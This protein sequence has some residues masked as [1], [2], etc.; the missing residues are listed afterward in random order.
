MINAGIL[1]RHLCSRICLD[2]EQTAL[3]LL[4]SSRRGGIIRLEF[5]V[6]P[7][8]FTYVFGQVFDPRVDF[9]SLLSMESWVPVF[10]QTPFWMKRVSSAAF[11]SVLEMFIG[12]LLPS[13]CQETVGE[14]GRSIILDGE[15]RGVN[16]SFSCN[17]RSKRFRRGKFSH[18]SCARCQY[19]ENPNG[20]FAFLIIIVSAEVLCGCELIVSGHCPAVHSALPMPVTPVWKLTISIRWAA[21]ELG[22]KDQW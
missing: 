2:I 7:E 18:L 20:I 1:A 16:I 11:F 17:S 12:N 22:P 13:R 10:A 9:T 5:D 21:D 14:L 19:A 15:H 3:H 8:I 4:H 6:A